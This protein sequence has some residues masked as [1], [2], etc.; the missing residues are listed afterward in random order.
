MCYDKVDIKGVLSRITK[1]IYYKQ[2]YFYFNTED[3][4]VKEKESLDLTK[5]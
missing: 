3:I 4:L 5:S 1:N 2:K